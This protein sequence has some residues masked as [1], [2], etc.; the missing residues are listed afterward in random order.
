M[1]R[2]GR[3][4]LALG[5]VVYAVAWVFGSRPLYPVAAGLVLAVALAW[6]SVRLAAKPMHVRRHGGTRE[7]LEGADVEVT[8]EVEPTSAAPPPSLTCTERIGRLGDRVVDLRRSGGRLVGRYTLAAVARGRYGFEPVGLA[9]EDPFGLYRVELEAGEPQALLVYPRLVE[10]ERLFSDGG[11]HAQEG[12]RVLLR[13]PSGFELHSVREYEQGESLRKVHW[14]ST[15]HRGQLMVKELEDAPRDEMAVLLD[16]DASVPSP[17]FDVQVRA[18]G[19]IL[20]AQVRRSRRC[21]LVVNSALREVQEVH[22]EGEWR[23]ALELLALVEPTA[24]AP[25]AGLVAAGSGPA[26]RALELVVVTARMTAALADALVQ[27]HLSHR[28]VSV[29]YVEPAAVSRPE[30]LLLRLT[31]A[32]IAVAVVRPGDDLATALGSPSAAEAAG[33]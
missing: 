16:G 26:G 23:R 9:V 19:S 30:P 7:Y 18:A 24:T 2:R 20:Q 17:T 5:L 33:A 3:S 13:R 27:R 31:A 14:R 6:A 4:V 28:S 1:T 22:G 32:G 10:L 29:A 8:V 21:V 15:A 25:A 11:S 12:R